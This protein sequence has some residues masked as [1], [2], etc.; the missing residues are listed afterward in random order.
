MH[1]LE[2]GDGLGMAFVFD[3]KDFICRRSVIHP[4]I[5]KILFDIS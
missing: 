4:W 1:V 3:V 5:D 2:K